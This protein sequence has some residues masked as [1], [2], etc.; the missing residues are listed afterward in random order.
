M[1]RGGEAIEHGERALAIAETLQEPTLRIIASYSL[2]LP[3]TIVGA[4]RT[5]I[6]FYQRDV[7]LKPEQ[8]AERLLE[9][10]GAGVFQEAFTRLSYSISQS[11]SALCFAELGEFDQA[12]LQ[13]ERGVK[14]AQTLDNLYVRAIADACL[15]FTHLRKGDP[16]KALHAAQ[17]WL[18]TY[19]AADVPFP[20]LVMAA[21][22]GEVFNV[23]GELDDA[24]VLFDQAWQFAES[25]SL[26]GWGQP[27]LAL[28]G[29]AYG[30]AGRNDQAVT[31]GQRALR[32][33]RQLGQRG[34]E[35]RSLYLLGNIH[36]YGA[37]ANANQARESYQ[38]A[39]VLA[40]ELAMRPLEAQC[41]FALGELAKKA[42]EKRG[43]QEQF[44]TAVSMFREMGMQFW[45]ERTESALKA[46]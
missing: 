37:A 15:G 25:K 21:T 2:G 26:L 40:H 27:V 12:L 36:G 44:S 11:M 17:R 33:A 7:G 1:G 34:V 29:D 31:T 5:A 20:Q 19:A 24:L 28:L 14:F 42:G 30:R 35:A 6:G 46:P 45:L 13:A 32:L 38:Q 3:H 23:S 10:W 16:Q 18:Q 22:L 8:I 43:A 39:L 41:H 9:P 4:F